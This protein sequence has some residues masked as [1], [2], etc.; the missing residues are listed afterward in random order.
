MNKRE[1]SQP[2]KPANSFMDPPWNVPWLDPSNISNNNSNNNFNNNN[3][4]PTFAFVKADILE[5]ELVLG[6]LHLELNSCPRRQVIFCSSAG[7]YCFVWDLK[8]CWKFVGNL[9]KIC[10]KFVEN[11][12]K[13]C[14]KIS[15]FGKFNESIIQLFFFFNL[16]TTFDVRRSTKAGVKKSE[17]RLEFENLNYFPVKN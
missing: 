1:T 2:L 9:L 17:L 7:R 11:L 3:Q 6:F 15:R 8:I 5:T 4:H 16:R 10:W 12:L 13:K 14:W